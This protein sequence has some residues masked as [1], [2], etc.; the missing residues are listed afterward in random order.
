MLW[1]EFL[2][3]QRAAEAFDALLAQLAWE[4][5]SIRMFG[6]E[7][8]EPRLVAWHGE[9]DAVYRYSGRTNLPQ[10]WTPLLMLLRSQIQELTGHTFNSVLANRY[11]SGSDAMGWHSDDEPE[12]GPAPTIA[13]LSLGSVRRMQLRPRPS[14]PIALAVDLPPG[15]LLLMAGHTQRAYH[16]RIARTSRP[17]GERIN[18]T[19]RLVL[20]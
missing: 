14:G 15:S 4:Q 12:L 6:R 11:R 17:V 13:S 18:L 7:I 1:P 9:P 2:S 5:R 16:H 20:S 19:F 10:P 8:P 3:E